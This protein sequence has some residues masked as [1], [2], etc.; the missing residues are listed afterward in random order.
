MTDEDILKNSWH[1]VVEDKLGFGFAASILVQDG[2]I[3][4]DEV[5]KYVEKTKAVFHEYF[6]DRFGI[7]LFSKCPK[8]GLGEMV[9]KNSLYGD[10]M[11]CSKYPECKTT[12]TDKHRRK[13]SR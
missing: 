7:D 10:F 2:L 5:E 6:I 13:K 4:D 3:L 8:C 12:Y 9:L 11:A 1:W